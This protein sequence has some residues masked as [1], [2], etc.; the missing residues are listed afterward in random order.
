MSFIDNSHFEDIGYHHADHSES[1][2]Q[3]SEMFTP[4]LNWLRQV[5]DD[6]ESIW[7]IL[8]CYLVHQQEAM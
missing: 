7:V 2:W 1:G 3:T 4:W 5:D 6:A 8:D